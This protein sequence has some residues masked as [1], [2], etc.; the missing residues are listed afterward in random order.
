MC[1]PGAGAGAGSMEWLFHV[2]PV[3]VG[4]AAC[5]SFRF[6]SFPG[7]SS[8]SEVEL[9]SLGQPL[10]TPSVPGRHLPDKL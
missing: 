2:V 8:C 5:S 9:L 4:K 1:V 6:P 3:V 7:P 10:A